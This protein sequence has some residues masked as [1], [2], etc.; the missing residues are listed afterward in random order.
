MPHKYLSLAVTDIKQHYATT[1]LRD[2]QA[3]E[4]VISGG[5]IEITSEVFSDLDITRIAT[6]ALHYDLT[7]AICVIDG[8]PRLLMAQIRRNVR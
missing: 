8:L 1:L 3:P 6:I 4:I 7:W 2:E 5:K